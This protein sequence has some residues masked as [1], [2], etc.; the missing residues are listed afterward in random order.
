MLHPALSK[1]T[2][3]YK[4]ATMA[5][6]LLFETQGILEEA[7]PEHDP[8]SEEAQQALTRIRHILDSTLPFVE[9]IR[10]AYQLLQKDR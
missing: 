1:M 8:I 10:Q 9:T 5:H 2:A 3:A 7:M 4:N 6:S